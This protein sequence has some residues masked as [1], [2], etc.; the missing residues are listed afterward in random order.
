[1]QTIVWNASTHRRTPAP[2]GMAS[3]HLQ[4]FERFPV[5]KSL[6]TRTVLANKSIL[7]GS[8]FRS[9]TSFLLYTGT[10]KLKTKLKG[11][12]DYLAATIQRQL[13]PQRARL[14]CRTLRTN[15]HRL[16][17]SFQSIHNT[18]NSTDG[19]LTNNP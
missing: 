10:T 6:L 14:V 4:T 16:R 1:M 9:I 11:E 2:R 15:I 12:T 7:T 17:V 19:C 5:N 3:Q 13:H 18:I 8:V